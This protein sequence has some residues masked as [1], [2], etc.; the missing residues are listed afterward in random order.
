MFFHKLELKD[1]IVLIGHVTLICMNLHN[2]YFAVSQKVQLCMQP[3]GTEQPKNDEYNYQTD[4][5]SLVPLIRCDIQ[6]EEYLL[7][8]AICL[9]NP[10][11][12]GLSEHAQRIIAKERQR[13][14]NALLDYC[15]KNRNGGP[16]RYVELLG[17]IPVLIHQQRLQKDIHIFHISPFISN[18]P[19]IFQFLEDIMFA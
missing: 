5:M 16:N 19:H 13:Y 9:C 7:L 8:K 6:F 2:S 17:I 15:L 11:V 1:K 12:H 18:L 3:D 14:A 4:S 10:T